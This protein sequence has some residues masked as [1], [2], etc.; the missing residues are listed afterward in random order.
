M[1]SAERPYRI[2]S[3]AVIRLLASPFRQAL[4]DEV[5]ATGAATVAH[6]SRRLHRPA[7]R[8]YYHVRLLER[9]GLLVAVTAGARHGREG[10]RYDVPGR[11]LLLQYDPASG[12]NRRAVGR[13]VDAMV[14]SARHDFRRAMRSRR[15]RVDGPRRELWAGRV[16]GILS[17]RDLEALNAHLAAVLELM[18]HSRRSRWRGGHPFQFTWVLSPRLRR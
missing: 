7:D 1:A 5:T 10:A 18:Q 12:A 8:L 14:R 6:L 11:P 15:I 16:E 9:A 4:L 3:I 17:V 13:V 2:R